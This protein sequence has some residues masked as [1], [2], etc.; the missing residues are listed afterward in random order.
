MVSHCSTSNCVCVFEIPVTE[1][2]AIKMVNATTVEVQIPPSNFSDKFNIRLEVDGIQCQPDGGDANE[3]QMQSPLD[4]LDSELVQALGRQAHALPGSGG[5]LF[6]TL[7]HWA[8]YHG[9]EKTAVVLLGLPGAAVD[10]RQA[11]R[12]GRNAHEMAADR[13]HQDLAV[14]I[15]SKLALSENASA[16]DVPRSQKDWYVVPP[17]PKPVQDTDDEDSYTPMQPRSNSAGSRFDVQGIQPRSHR[18]RSLNDDI[19]NVMKSRPPSR[20]E[21]IK[22]F[23]N[24]SGQEV[25][26]KDDDFGP[27]N[28]DLDT[29]PRCCSTSS[30]ESKVIED[31]PK[32]GSWTSLF[33][34]FKPGSSRKDPAKKY[35]T[36]P[37]KLPINKKC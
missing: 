16:Y 28:L 4:D 30:D 34:H 2:K 13:G 21:F 5:Q 27:I 37:S 19:L 36:L 14:L 32:A 8:A 6:P 12:N 26:L 17:P 20:Q 1:L 7:L 9:L 35:S 33:T 24:L 3:M 29:G 15:R 25:I 11:N 31:R 22:T 18:T 23:C 10:I